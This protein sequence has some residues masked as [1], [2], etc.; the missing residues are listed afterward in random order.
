METI[1]VF[2]RKE[3]L[4]P[5]R[6][7]NFHSSIV[8]SGCIFHSYIPAFDGATGNSS[9]ASSSNGTSCCTPRNVIFHLLMVVVTEV[10]RT[11][12]WHEHWAPH[13]KQRIHWNILMRPL[14]RWNVYWG[15]N[16]SQPTMPTAVPPTAPFRANV[17][18]AKPTGWEP[19]Q[20]LNNAS[21]CRRES[22]K[23]EDGYVLNL[24]S[25]W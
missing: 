1:T 12:A 17:A 4:T 16:P 13:S 2:R 6:P 15:R 19:N 8:T 5:G 18:D 22:C 10:W 7:M 3:F 20:C 24:A 11:L 14:W 9:L 21:Y 23:F 25:I